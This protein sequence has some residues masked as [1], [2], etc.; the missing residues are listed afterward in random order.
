MP[1][2]AV[3]E[4]APASTADFKSLEEKILRTIE[5]LKSAR[6]GRAVAERDAARLREQLNE[7][8]EEVETMRHELVSLRREREEVRGRVE[9]MLEQIEAL[10]GEE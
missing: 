3:E 10:A 6:E 1:V 9:K 2:N 7:R 5:L 8:E 4:I